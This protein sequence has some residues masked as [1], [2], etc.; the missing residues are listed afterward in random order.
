[1]NYKTQTGDS[2]D[3]I[4]WHHYGSI[5]GTVEALLE[6]NPKLADMGLHL[7]AG[8]LITLPALTLP[9]TQAQRVT[10]WG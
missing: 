3:A 5:Q 9:K 1:M 6:A 10:L 8:I 2:L 7:P 4:A